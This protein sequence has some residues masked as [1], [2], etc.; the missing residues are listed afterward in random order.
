MNPGNARERHFEAMVL[1]MKSEYC[2]VPGNT[3]RKIKCLTNVPGGYIWNGG[4]YFVTTNRLVTTPF[5]EE[6]TAV[7]VPVAKL[8]MSS[9]MVVVPAPIPFWVVNSF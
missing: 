8:L 5:A 2:Q 3:P 9:C 6:I 7:Y 1:K 4:F